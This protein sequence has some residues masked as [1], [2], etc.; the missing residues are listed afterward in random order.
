MRIT[1]QTEIKPKAVAKSIPNQQKVHAANRNPSQI[2]Q[3]QAEIKQKS[4]Q[5]QAQ[6]KST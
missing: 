5:N 6:I 4:I 1:N 3:S 2:K